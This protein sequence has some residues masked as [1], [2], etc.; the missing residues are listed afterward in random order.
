MA[1]IAQ[2]NRELPPRN[3]DLNQQHRQYQQQQQQDCL[4][5]PGI[6]LMSGFHVRIYNLFFSQ[7]VHI[8]LALSK[9][10]QLF[11]RKISSVAPP[12]GT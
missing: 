12:R 3:R 4:N 11:Y 10:A 7:S 2:V 5:R 1:T 9:A 8:K 6:N